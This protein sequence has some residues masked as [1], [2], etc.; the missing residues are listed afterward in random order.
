MADDVTIHNN[1]AGEG[2]SFV[3]ATDDTGTGHVQLVKLVQ[4]ANGSRTPIEADGDGMEVKVTNASLT[5]DG[6]VATNPLDDQTQ[7]SSGLTTASTTYATG[8]VLGAGWTFTSMATASGGHG[9][10]L[11]ISCLDISDVME[12]LLLWFSKASITFGTDNAAPSVSDADAANLIG[13]PV[14]VSFADLGGCRFGSVDSVTIPYVCAATS[15]F[16]YA[17]T[18]SA[19]AVFAGGADS[20]KLTLHYS[21]VD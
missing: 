10:I 19:N 20:L 4:S 3:A 14:A 17:T 15:L 2:T 13:G 12:G 18:L 7:A 5:V 11:G 21:I 16:V 1:A 8:D 6:V 9:K